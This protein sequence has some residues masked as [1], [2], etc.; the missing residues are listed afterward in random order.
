M[1]VITT[2]VVKYN[3]DVVWYLIFQVAIIVACSS[4]L[5]AVVAVISYLSIPWVI[6]LIE[7]NVTLFCCL[8]FSFQHIMGC[9]G[10]VAY[11]RFTS[12]SMYSTNF[13]HTVLTSIHFQGVRDISIGK[14][15]AFTSSWRY[16]SVYL[17]SIWC[18]AFS[19]SL[20]CIHP[21]PVQL[22]DWF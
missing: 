13:F 12:S 4:I 22:I 6:K 20:H 16:M 2:E 11:S 17:F 8:V 7:A 15:A 19:L 18:L 1:S 5:T 14:V 9:C 10:N 3:G 21:I